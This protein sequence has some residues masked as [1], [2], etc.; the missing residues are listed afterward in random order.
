MLILIAPRAGRWYDRIGARPLLAAGSLVAAA[1][2]GWLAFALPHQSYAWLV[3]AYVLRG[4]GIALVTAPSLTDAMNVAPP[5]GR[6]EAAGLLG[7]VQQLG[8]TIGTA[9]TT[10]VLVP[11]FVHRLAASV[12]RPTELVQTAL[13]RT[14]GGTLFSAIPPSVI[15]AAKAAFASSLAVAF[16]LVAGL[17]VVSFLIALLVHSHSRPSGPATP[18]VPG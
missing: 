11:L 12:G 13:A 5:G 14:R 9:V 18:A 4:V 10:A 16:V 2:F 3:P 8:A 17:M 1:G 7:T 6:G 15:A